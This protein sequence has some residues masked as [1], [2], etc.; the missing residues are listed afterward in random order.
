MKEYVF[1][2]ELKKFI[3]TPY[4]WGGSS[5]NGSDCSGSVCR[6]MSLALGFRRRVTADSLYRSFFTEE[7]ESFAAKGFIYAAF[8]LDGNGSAVHVAGWCGEGY[9]NVSRV[10]RNGGALR[11]EKEMM[12][13]Y[14]HLVFKRRRMKI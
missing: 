9:V 8:F 3:G 10:E 14:S 12:T 5:V 2:A 4:V 13:L 11:S 7:A 6:A 1:C